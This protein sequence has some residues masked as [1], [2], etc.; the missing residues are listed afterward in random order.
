MKILFIGDIV[1]GPGRKLVKRVLPQ[2]I[3]EHS[4]DVVFANAENIS[5][6]R[7]ITPDKLGELVEAGVDYFTSGDHVYWER[8][9]DD[10]I[11]DV[12]VLIPANY[13]EGN[14]GKRYALIEKKGKKIL[15]FNM[16]G[17]TGF[18]P[19]YGYLDDPF[20]IADNILARFL[21]KKPDYIFL[22]FHAEASSEKVAMGHY[23]D[24]RITGMVGTHTHIPTCDHMALSKGT[25][26]VSDIGMTG[27]I[28][29]VLGVKTNIIINMFKTARNQRFEWETAGRKAFRSVLFDT[30]S[31]Q[32][33]RL[34]QVFE[35]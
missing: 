1:A 34:D 21:D 31:N 19:I 18:S 6:G 29:S 12:P 4:I 9:T 32:I 28:D 33:T 14:P 30:D 17:R 10:F 7:G 27:I 25:M 8:S 15:L 26:Y 35:N 24:G 5:G 13:P 3:R 22:D 16:M 11:E 23:L 20:M 2:L